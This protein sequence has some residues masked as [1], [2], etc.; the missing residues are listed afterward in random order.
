M[1]SAELARA[2]NRQAM[3]QHGILTQGRNC[4]RITRAQRAAF[5]MTVRHILPRLRRLLSRP[6][7]QFSSWGGTS[8][9]ASVLCPRLGQAHYR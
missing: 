7:N 8:T 3:T 1:R 6:K 5:L 4:W 9:A 2:D